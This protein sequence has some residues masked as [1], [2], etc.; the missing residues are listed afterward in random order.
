MFGYSICKISPLQWVTIAVAPA[1]AWSWVFFMSK[2]AFFV[3]GFNLYHA[4][5]YFNGG[6]NHRRYQRYKWISLTRLANCYVTRKDR[7]EE[8]LYFTTLA[9]WDRAK[10]DRHKLFIRAQESEGVKIVYGEFKRKEKKCQ[11]C[12]KYFW[13]YEEKQTDVNIALSLLQ[14]AV[15]DR[16]DRR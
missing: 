14:L 8:I 7:I 3:D 6:P 5:D 1:S 9:T 15:Q 10:V 12:H 4:L 16:Y 13:T 2:C 11:L